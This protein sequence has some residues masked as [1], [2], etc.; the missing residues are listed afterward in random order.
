MNLHDLHIFT[1]AARFGSVTRAAKA[2]GTVQSNVTMRIRVLEEELEVPLFRRSHRG[3]ELTSKGQDLLPYAQQILALVQTAKERVSGK[4]HEPQ[5][6]LRIGSLQTT[7]AARLPDL[8]K[9]YAARFSK[10]DISVETGVSP[11]L[12]ER[13][14]DC[15][16]EG[17][18]VTATIERPDLNV[19][20]AFTEEVVGLTPLSFRSIKSYLRHGSIPKVL[21]C[22]I[23]CSYRQK[24][25]HFLSDEGF[26]QLDEMEFGTFEGIIGCVSAGLGMSMLPRSVVERS[27][28]RNEV[29]IHVLP[30][31]A[32]LM[33]TSFVTRS[34]DMRSGALEGLIET[35]VERRRISLRG[36][37]AGVSN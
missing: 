37:K 22:R 35:I 32:N 11:E 6:R 13:V 1:T 8:L 33:E 15:R 23:G 25:E 30:K 3:V 29:R 7:A 4:E 28:R 19:I 34:G 24:L 31:S 26:D 18:F 36:K 10:V 21:V 9:D 14:L 27:A 20:P 2:L 17:A 16:I 12:I 5:G